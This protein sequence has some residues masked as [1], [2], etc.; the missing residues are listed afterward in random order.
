MRR[1]HPLILITLFALLLIAGVIGMILEADECWD[2]GGV[3]LPGR[4][5]RCILD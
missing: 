4:G 1:I 2:Q 5:D 3:V